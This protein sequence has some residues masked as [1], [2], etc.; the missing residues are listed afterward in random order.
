MSERSLK[1]RVAVEETKVRRTTHWDMDYLPRDEVQAL[2]ARGTSRPAEAS[3]SD[4]LPK[5]LPPRQL[6]IICIAVGIGLLVV[7]AAAAR[8]LSG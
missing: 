8:F 5:S 1:K 2:Y 6:G 4:P 3:A 7:A